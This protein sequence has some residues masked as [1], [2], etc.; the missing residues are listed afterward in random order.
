MTVI[1]K[2]FNTSYISFA[3]CS[4]FFFILSVFVYFM[5][6]RW[7]LAGHIIKK[8]KMTKKERKRREEEKRN[9]S[10]K[11]SLKAFGRWVLCLDY[12]DEQKGSKI[13]FTLFFILNYFYLLLCLSFVIIF[14]LSFWFP[15]LQKWGIIIFNIKLHIIE[16]PILVLLAILFF[17]GARQK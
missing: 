12:T 7:L 2:I 5:I 4:V 10:K 9:R 17:T 8:P 3:T 14:I 11:D 1:E 15:D 13:L 6:I 16:Y